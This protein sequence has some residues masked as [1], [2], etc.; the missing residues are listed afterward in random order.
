VVFGPRQV[1]WHNSGGGDG[2][3]AGAGGTGKG[4]QKQK[5][6]KCFVLTQAD[7]GD[8]A[9]LALDVKVI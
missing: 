8:Q 1:A 2:G 5:R 3:E 9:A 4:A 6:R 7:D